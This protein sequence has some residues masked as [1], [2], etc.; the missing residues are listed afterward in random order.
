M[1]KKDW[2][3]LIVQK[4]TRD[5]VNKLAKEKG[6]TQDDIINILLKSTSETARQ[7]L[8][9]LDNGTYNT[10]NDVSRFLFAMKCIEKP[11]KNLAVRLAINN[12]I[13]GVSK[14]V[15]TNNQT[16]QQTSM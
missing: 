3:T 1:A 15:Q 13:Q 11:D 7:I 16:S 4:T 12:L 10:L 2:T 6:M 5:T 9:D 8:I 14:S